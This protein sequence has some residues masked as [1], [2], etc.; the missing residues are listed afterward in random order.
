MSQQNVRLVAR[1]ITAINARDIEAS[2]A[3]GTENVKLETQWS[4]LE[5]CM[6]ESIR[7]SGA[8][9]STDLAVDQV[10]YVRQGTRFRGFESPSA[11]A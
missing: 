4:P 1:A 6:K 10:V 9:S 2:L 3:Y 11:S 7:K 5:G 8:A